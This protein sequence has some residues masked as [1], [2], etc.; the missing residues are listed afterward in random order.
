MAAKKSPTVYRQ[1]I[2]VWVMAG[3]LTKADK[4]VPKLGRDPA[5]ANVG[6][7]TRSTVLRIALSR[8]LEA[9]TKEY[10]A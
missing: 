10:N 6:K 3:D 9:L 2:S 5:V 7:V 4:L 1:Q 8:G